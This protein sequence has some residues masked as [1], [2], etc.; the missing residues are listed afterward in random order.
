MGVPTDHAV[1]LQRKDYAPAW[2]GAFT[3]EEIALLARFGHWMEA[4][5]AELR[6]EGVKTGKSARVGN[7]QAVC[8]RGRVAWDNKGLQKYAETHPEVVH[9]RK[10]GE[11]GVAIRYK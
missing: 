4:L 8:D 3:A 6:A 2:P 10:V 9:Y 1:Y 5:T 7:I 11:A